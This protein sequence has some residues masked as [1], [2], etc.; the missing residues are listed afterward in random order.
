MRRLDH[1]TIYL[2]I[3]ATYTPFGLPALTGAWRWTVLPIVWAARWVAI[4]CKV[5]WV[6][7][8]NWI[9]ALMAVALGWVGIVAL[10]ELW[11][12][13]GADGIALLGVGGAL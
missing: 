6:D 2:L 3:A 13:I 9:S 10:P 4:V 5:P 1:A 12:N 7:G 11:G 8:P